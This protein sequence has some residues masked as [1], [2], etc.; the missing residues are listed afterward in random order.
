MLLLLLVVVVMLLDLSGHW[1]TEC[2]GT[3]RSVAEFLSARG[4][5]G[6]GI[7]NESIRM[8]KCVEHGG[9]R[10]RGVAMIYSLN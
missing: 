7:I 9:D 8:I 2:E 6:V 10:G 5:P 1:G 4:T 3:C